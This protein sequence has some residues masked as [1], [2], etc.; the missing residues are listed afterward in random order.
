MVDCSIDLPPDQAPGSR[1]G[2][3]LFNSSVLQRLTDQADTIERVL[4][5]ANVLRDL[6]RQH[7]TPPPVG[8]WT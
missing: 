2:R 8:S 3:W 5:M 6:Q 4:A 1:S 7:F